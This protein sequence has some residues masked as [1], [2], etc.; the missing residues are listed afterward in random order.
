MIQ[1]E[2]KFLKNIKVTFIIMAKNFYIRKIE[3][4]SVKHKWSVYGI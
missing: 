3:K 1:F 2:K 4:H